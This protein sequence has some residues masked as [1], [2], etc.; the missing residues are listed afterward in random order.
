MLFC[1]FGFFEVKFSKNIC[2]FATLS[3]ATLSSLLRKYNFN[4]LMYS[5][6]TDVNVKIIIDNVNLTTVAR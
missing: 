5:A 6:A 3:N 2:K 4:L 1:F